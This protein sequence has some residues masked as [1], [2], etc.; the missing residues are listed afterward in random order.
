VADG[1][2][3]GAPAGGPPSGLGGGSGPPPPPGRVVARPGR[4]TLVVVEGALPVPVTRTR[5][6]QDTVTETSPDNPELEFTLRRMGNRER[7]KRQDL[8]AKL[9]YVQVDN[10]GLVTE[11]ELPMGQVALEDIL[12]GLVGWNIEDPP[13]KQVPI[14]KETIQDYLSPEE[15]DFVLDKIRDLNPIVFGERTGT[16]GAHGANGADG[17]AGANGRAG[18]LAAGEESGDGP[19][20]AGA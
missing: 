14:T 3:G 8:F 10:E 16:N 13:G 12:M 2:D 1:A 4:P 17:A 9:R 7:I 20:A 11:R 6:L 5:I 15:F 19:P 18:A